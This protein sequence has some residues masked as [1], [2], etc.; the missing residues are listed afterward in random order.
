MLAYLTPSPQQT[1]TLVYLPIEFLHPS[2]AQPRQIFQAESLAEL[3]ASITAEGIIQPLIVRKIAGDSFEIIAGERR[4]RA[5]QLAQLAQVPVVIKEL[6]DQS[7]TA[8]ALIENIQR[9]DLNPLEEAGAFKK[10]LTNFSMTHQQLADSLGKSRAVISNTL[11]LLELAEPVKQLV[12]E[13]QLNMGQARALLPLESSLQFKMAKKVV[14]LGLTVRAVEQLV[15]QLQANK[16]IVQKSLL[17]PD[18]LHLQERLSE[19]LNTRVEIK[20]QK[21][22]VGQLVISY[23][24]LQELDGI[25]RYFPITS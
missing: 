14:K 1:D 9:E 21:N 15:Q 20:Q 10:L 23:H 22:G 4:W 16:Q 13:G 6:D 3:A 17:D 2:S 24:S 25:L 7:A 8:I 5:A 19:T 11:R 12:L 18:T